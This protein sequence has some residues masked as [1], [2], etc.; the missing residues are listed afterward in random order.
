MGT[1]I[2]RPDETV[3]LLAEHSQGVEPPI[4]TGPYVRKLRLREGGG[5]VMMPCDASL[6]FSNLY[7]VTLP[8]NSEKKVGHIWE[9]EQGLWIGYSYSFKSRCGPFGI[10]ADAEAEVVDMWARSFDMFMYRGYR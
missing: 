7:P 4:R 1:K 6:L 9:T 3:G 8:H 10:R 2:V 5:G